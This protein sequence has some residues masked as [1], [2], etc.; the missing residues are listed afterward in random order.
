MEIGLGRRRERVSRAN[1]FVALVVEAPTLAAALGGAPAHVRTFHPDDLHATIAFLGPVSRA[2]AD[3]GWAALALD[4]APSDVRLG[5][6][7][8]LGASA[9]SALLESPAIDRA[10]GAARGAV[11]K[12]AAAR[13]DERPPL[14]HVTVA[15]IGRRASPPERRA[16]IAWAASLDLTRCPARIARVALYTWAEDRRER[17]FR[18][19]ESRMLG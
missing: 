4:L 5:R 1:W 18:V 6:V 8:A 7:E 3:A 12:A 10:I 14:G 16:A 17:L 9:L 19:V 2:A 11:W 13:P 15:R